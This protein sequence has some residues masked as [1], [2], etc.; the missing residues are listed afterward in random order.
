M[1]KKVL[2][3]GAGAVGGYV[4]G[5]LAQAGEDVLLVDPWPEHVDCI[6]REGLHLHTPE[7]EII[8]QVPCMHLH[9]VQRLDTDPVDIAFISTKSYDTEWAAALIKQYLAPAGFIVSLQNSINEERIAGVVG[10]G[11]TVGCIVSGITVE[12]YEAGHII[13]ALKPGTSKKLVFRAGEVHGR[14]TPRVREI[15]EMLS[16]VDGAAATTNLWGERW[17]KLVVNTMNNAVSTVTGLNSRM[18]V[19]QEAPR[20][21]SIKIGCET[22][23]VGRAL[24]YEFDIIRGMKSATLLAAGRGE[25]GAAREIYHILSESVKHKTDA[26]RPSTAQ[27]FAKGRR[28]EIDFINGLVVQKGKEVEVPT[29]LN[30]AI[31]RLVKRIESGELNQDPQHAHDI[32]N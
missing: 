19:E 3:F 20:Q 27:D 14:M 12:L 7:E 13:R 31:T 30:A 23:Q 5:Q 4:G 32:L 29:P 11:K 26:G 8:V 10:W 25:P 24:G 17:T 2:I 21:L 18:I 15:V 16:V 28:T 6:K 22:I 9:E 1:K